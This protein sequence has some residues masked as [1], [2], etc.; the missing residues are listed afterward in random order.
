MK[1]SFVRQEHY[2][3]QFVLKY[4]G[5]TN[6]KVSFVNVG[7]SPIKMLKGSALKVMQERD[8]Y[9]IKNDEGDYV[10]RN[11]IEKRYSDIESY[12]SPFYNKFLKMSQK[13]DF[14]TIFKETVQSEEWAEIESSLLLYLIVLLIRGKGLKK[15]SY[16]K[17]KLPERYQHILHLMFT[18]NN[19]VAAEFVKKIYYGE[20]LEGVLHFIKENENNLWDTLQKHIMGNYQIRVFKTKETNRLFL[21]DN[22][23]II[24]KFE[25]E[26][27]I[28][29]LSPELCV[30]L[31]P[32]NV[33]GD[34]VKIDTKIFGLDNKA[35]NKINAQS[36]K[37]TD[38]LLIISN[39]ND[40][41]FIKKHI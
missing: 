35:V 11:F 26:D 4:F 7:A 17:T 16:S 14:D 19:A 21:S 10:L 38:Q 6:G 27:Y 8:F 34:L 41:E 15:I 18:T 20:E 31:V 39:E 33:E 23:I 24:Q 28:L 9:E 13:E 36:I 40:L 29:P 22:P 3:P 30:F 37:N 2:I 32:L 5:D 25:G 1:N 12:I